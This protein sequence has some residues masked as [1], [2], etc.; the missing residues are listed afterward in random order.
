MDG[1]TLD[2]KSQLTT[3][4]PPQ[5]SFASDSLNFATQIPN[6]QQEQN[7]EILSNGRNLANQGRRK[8][9]VLSLI[10]PAL[11][12]TKPPP[13]VS[14]RKDEYEKGI[15]SFRTPKKRLSQPS[16]P[17]ESPDNAQSNTTAE[18][19]LPKSGRKGTTPSS[20]HSTSKTQMAFVLENTNSRTVKGS[21][22][23]AKSST[24]INEQA[25]QHARIYA[26]QETSRFVPRCY[27]RVEKDQKSLLD[28]EDSWFNMSQDEARIPKRVFQDQIK[29]HE[30]QAAVRVSVNN[31]ERG[32]DTDSDAHE[33][34]SVDDSEDDHAD[35][36]VFHGKNA[37]QHAPF[38]GVAFGEGRHLLQGKK[39]VED[40]TTNPE[41]GYDSGLNQKASQIAVSSQGSDTAEAER[42][43]STDDESEFS[44]PSPA[45][46]SRPRKQATTPATGSPASNNFPSSPPS[47][48]NATPTRVNSWKSKSGINT[49]LFESDSFRKRMVE[50]PAFSVTTPNRIRAAGGLREAID[51][52][53][54]S[55]QTDEEEL[56]LDIPHALGEVIPKSSP[57]KGTGL[58]VSPQ[59]LSTRINHSEL[60]IQVEK[61]P[62]QKKR[63]NIEPSPDLFIPGTYTSSQ[64]H[65]I[66]D[67]SKRVD[68]IVASQSTNTDF[69]E[70]AT[71]LPLVPMTMA[72]EMQDAGSTDKSSSSV[73]VS[74]RRLD[75]PSSA[76]STIDQTLL[77]FQASSPVP[78]PNLDG[79]VD[80]LPIPNQQL[81]PHSPPRVSNVRE[82]VDHGEQPKKRRKIKDLAALGF[83]QEDMS[84]IDRDQMVRA[85]R[86]EIL[87]RL[88]SIDPDDVSAA[89]ERTKPTIITEHETSPTSVNSRTPHIRG[90]QSVT[91]ENNQ[92]IS[93]D[94]AAA[95][96][97]GSATAEGV[98]SDASLQ[99]EKQQPNL[100]ELYHQAY[101]N[102]GGTEKQFVKAL[103]Y[104]EWLGA[105]RRPNECLW[106]DF[107]RCYAQDY[108]DH[109][110]ISNSEQLTGIQF[111]NKLR[112][113]NVDYFHTKA[114]DCIVTAGRLESA[115]ADGSL[116]CNLVETLREK[117]S[118]T[119]RPRASHI[120]SKGLVITEEGINHQTSLDE[121]AITTTH[122]NTTEDLELP[123]RSVSRR[124]FET[125]SQVA[126]QESAKDKEEPAIDP[127]G[128]NTS[129]PRSAR[130]SLPWKR[131]VETPSKSSSPSRSSHSKNT[132][133]AVDKSASRKESLLV[134]AGEESAIDL[135]SPATSIRSSEISSRSSLSRPISQLPSSRSRVKVPSDGQRDV[136][137]VL[138]QQVQSS[139][140]EKSRTQ[141]PRSSILPPSFSL[142]KLL[143]K[144]C[145]KRGGVL[146]R[147]IPR[148]S[149]STKSISSNADN[150]SPK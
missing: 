128:V 23:D 24:K 68:T 5:A 96:I 32:Q 107:V 106:D 9:D 142:G 87:R 60:L 54:F 26:F 117:Y 6:G 28:C 133:A 53:L 147:T 100:Y 141:T 131:S 116:D 37:T 83:S 69:S 10:E 118:M 66:A 134:L 89:M 22:N 30:S 14:F 129:S 135:T 7:T 113:V 97:S 48:T 108:S 140:V 64:P 101:P 145:K 31:G 17:Q 40:S 112:E 59:R 70:R 71:P 93:L 114:S 137:K 61:T 18:R 139:R 125:Y 8:K 13:L 104:L 132:K 78:V 20:V 34:E 58:Q 27:E 16:R 29:F 110:R 73:Q 138:K 63:S 51:K 123:N 146:S 88:S 4:S 57:A 82:E 143:A 49:D 50:S 65:P 91:S 39:L 81:R 15:D 150:D 47:R 43:G 109:L 92:V 56:E 98:N 130:R 105:S 95:P 121:T 76:P 12:T 86:R 102:Y 62:S 2:K 85:S 119:S 74:R 79:G 33:E 3:N 122:A 80:I 72:Q 111:Y 46:N 136:E 55:S 36:Q 149:F 77:V 75:P 94:L 84:I 45:V 19:A 148:S 25:D 42:S 127:A 120:P 99:A 1:A 35:A 11:P 144:T 21:P 124:F 41:Q 52:P 44:Q 103:V 126:A 67:E 38:I 115:L 90:E